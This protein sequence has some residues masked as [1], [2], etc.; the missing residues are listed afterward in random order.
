MARLAGGQGISQS[1]GGCR[2][3]S[4]STRQKPP[5]GVAQLQ[6]IG[7]V[8]VLAPNSAPSTSAKPAALPLGA[9]VNAQPLLSHY[10]GPTNSWLV[11]PTRWAGG[12][13]SEA[14]RPPRAQDAALRNLSPHPLDMSRFKS[15]K[16]RVSNSSITPL[17]LLEPPS[18]P[19]TIS[20]RLRAA[21]IAKG[22]TSDH[23]LLP[24]VWPFT[25][26]R[27]HPVVGRSIRAVVTP[28][29]GPR[30]GAA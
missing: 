25:G 11:W 6:Y 7:P 13:E 29:V 20:I 16:H 22:T 10:Q 9:R 15:T 8:H 4:S 21:Q 3:R 5:W 23:V 17:R 30:Y 2:V 27:G 26:M 14:A 1:G 18:G 12:G 24:S 19:T 28:S